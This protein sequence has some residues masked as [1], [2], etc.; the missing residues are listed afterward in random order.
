M[1]RAR[2][3]RSS[4]TSS[5]QSLF[6]GRDPIG[7]TIKIFGEPFQVIGL[8]AEAASLFSNADEPRL[9][10]PHTVFAKVAD[11]ERGWMEI[12]VVPTAAATTLE[13]QDEVT[14][15]LRSARGLKPAR[16]EQL[17]D[18]DAGPGARG[19]QQDHGRLLHRDDRAVERRRSWWAAS[20]WWRS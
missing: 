16:A 6:P 1:P 15:A 5:P 17:R 11:Y 10:I 9:A 12:A 14:A 8:H 20:A 4:T 13:A 18:R 2:G 3:W 19:V 7:K